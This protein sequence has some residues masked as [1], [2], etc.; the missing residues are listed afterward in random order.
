MNSSVIAIIGSNGM[1]GRALMAACEEREIEAWGY[2]GRRV[3]DVTDADAVCRSL[4]RAHLVIN[5]SGYTDVDGAESDPEAAMRVNHL[6]PMNL[7]RACRDNDALLVH[8]S[9]DYVFRGV[10]S[11]VYRVD[12]EL[13]PCNVYG[14]SKL[15]GERAIREVGCRHLI[16]RTSWL[17]APYGR[18]FVRSILSEV[19]RRPVL[20]V[21]ADQTGRPTSC[22]DLA[23]MTFD[24]IE[25]GAQG[26]FH[27]ANRGRCT[28]YEFARE[29]VGRTGSRCQ[30]SACKTSEFPRPAKRPIF[31]VLD[32]SETIKV[33]GKSRH[34][35]PALRDCLESL[36]PIGES[37]EGGSKSLPLCEAIRKIERNNR[38]VLS[39]GGPRRG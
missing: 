13:G 20:K 8:Y 3:L 21:V 9:T 11:S 17:F 24:L 36:V 34:W 30:L 2:A 16:I 12:D 15:A 27:A 28:W 38:P 35:R 4:R 10:T 23:E 6:G 22:R 39:S 26:T 32:L 37:Y 25:A 14:S 33:I 7:A 5:A 31:S 29:I 1:L 18:N 19:T